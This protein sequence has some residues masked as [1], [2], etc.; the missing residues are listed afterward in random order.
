MTH[1]PE[2]PELLEQYM[3]SSGSAECWVTVRELRSFFQLDNSAGPAFSG[4]LQKIH[5]G[6]SFSCRYK[7]ARIE[8]FRDKTPPYRIIKKYLIQKRPV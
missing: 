3:E 2:F 1:H 6:Q 8:K 4:F 7:V 5:H